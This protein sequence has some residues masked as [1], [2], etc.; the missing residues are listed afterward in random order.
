MASEEEVVENLVLF[1]YHFQGCHSRSGEV[2]PA[3]SRRWLS[4]WEWQVFGDPIVIAKAAGS[5]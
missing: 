3:N 2:L 1:N 4:T 5:S